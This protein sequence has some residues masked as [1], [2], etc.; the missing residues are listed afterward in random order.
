MTPTMLTS[1]RGPE[2]WGGPREDCE[3]GSTKT[4]ALFKNRADVY[5]G[6]VQCTFDQ[7]LLEQIP[8]MV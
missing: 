3:L 6:I 5:V 2:D 1:T 7:L 4:R 8:I